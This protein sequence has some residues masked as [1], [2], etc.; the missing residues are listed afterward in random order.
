MNKL[1]N[2]KTAMTHKKVYKYQQRGYNINWNGLYSI[3]MMS[4]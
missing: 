1:H 3:V 4:C 2:A